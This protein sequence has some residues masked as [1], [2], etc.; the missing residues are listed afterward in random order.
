MKKHSQVGISMVEVMIA[1]LI[2]AFLIGGLIQLFIGSKQTYNMQDANSR[3]Q[4]NG[5][6]AIGFLSADVH[7]AAFWGCWSDPSKRNDVFSALSLTA[8]PSISGTDNT[9]INGSDSITVSGFK[10]KGIPITGASTDTSPLIIAPN[11]GNSLN[12]N[13]W[14]LVTD[15]EDANV[16]QV[17]KDVGAGINVQHALHTLNSYDITT[18]QA[19]IFKWYGATYDI[20]IGS[21]GLPSLF[22]TE[23]NPDGTTHGV[24]QELVEGIENMQVLYGEDNTPL[25]AVGSCADCLPSRYVPAT[26]V[27]NINRVYGVRISL[28]AESIS[29][30]IASKPITYT[31]NG[32]TVIP[33]DRRMRNVY[34]ITLAI[35]SRLK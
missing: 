26:Q 23:L 18:R 16:F 35:R 27:T 29:D 24:P 3:L 14:A 17:T 25:D 31:Y 12:A 22:R 20:R 1:L 5:R 11:T 7:E 32:L 15:C 33:N 2:G 21:N 19:Q 9:G 8:V 28:L 30:N 4:E 6:F 34:N 13:D 10:Y